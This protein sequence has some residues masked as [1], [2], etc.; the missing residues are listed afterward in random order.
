[1]QHERGSV[2]VAPLASMAFTRELGSG[3]R[4]W[5]VSQ[6]AQFKSGALF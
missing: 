4:Q 1:M 6:E 5:Q 3:L 2:R